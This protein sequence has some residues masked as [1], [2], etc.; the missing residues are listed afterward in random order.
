MSI[1]ITHHTYNIALTKKPFEN[2]FYLRNSPVQ[3]LPAAAKR[4]AALDKEYKIAAKTLTG[5]GY[6]GTMLD[7]ELPKVKKKPIFCNEEAWIQHII[8]N[9]LMN[10]AGGLFKTGLISDC[11]KLQSCCGGRDEN[12]RARKEGKGKD[13]KT[14]EEHRVE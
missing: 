4:L 8:D 5:M 12:V 13:K 11:C 9:N 14:E 10:K 2:N 1:H 3:P 6:N 7:C